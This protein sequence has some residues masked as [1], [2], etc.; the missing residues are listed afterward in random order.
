[1]VVSAFLHGSDNRTSLKHLER[2]TEIEE[3]KLLKCGARI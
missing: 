1:M 3:M 2:R